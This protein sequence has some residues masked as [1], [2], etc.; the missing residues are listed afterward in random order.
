MVSRVTSVIAKGDENILR[1]IF[2]WRDVVSQLRVTVRP[3]VLLSC[4]FLL[5]M[6]IN[7]LPI[8]GQTGAFKPSITLSNLVLS[9]ALGVDK[10]EV[11]ASRKGE[12]TINGRYG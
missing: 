5:G 9:I 8:K 11:I 10:R 12:K 1:V 6:V 7:A 3:L 4:C 2:R